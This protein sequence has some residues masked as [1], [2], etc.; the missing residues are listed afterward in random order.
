MN[1][2]KQI[3]PVALFDEANDLQAAGHNKKALEILYD[4]Y[5]HYT[6][7]IEP[8]N[9][10]MFIGVC[11][12]NL[13]END[14]A[15]EIFLKAKDSLEEIEGNEFDFLHICFHLG[16]L[17]YL[18]C[19][20]EKAIQTFSQV[21]HLLSYYEDKGYY[22]CIQIF[23]R[24]RGRC[25]VY[26]Y[27]YL[28]A[29]KDL[30]M[31]CQLLDKVDFGDDTERIRNESIAYMDLLRSEIF[32]NEISNAK[33]YFAKVDVSVLTDFNLEDYYFLLM[34]YHFMADNYVEC[35]K[36]YL[37]LEKIGLPKEH[38]YYIY[39]SLGMM[40]LKAED[41]KSAKKYLELTIEDPDIP[42]NDKKRIQGY[43][44]HIRRSIN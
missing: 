14:K 11:H 2:N 39:Y 35:R 28:L 17:E 10:L 13:V 18:S 4:L 24:N 12:Y 29:S 8:S 9:L 26:L 31:A 41:Y 20:F 38:I 16:N 30:K 40:D 15:Y 34:K 43:L 42:E 21:E 33:E 22:D 5:E 3:D 27:K 32:R 19:E 36:A 44:D 23:Y 1:N 6:D 25:Y 7:V 37:A